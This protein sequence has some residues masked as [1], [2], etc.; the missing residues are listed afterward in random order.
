MPSALLDQAIIIGRQY[1]QAGRFADAE[2]A[3]QQV[4]AERPD[5]PIAL[6]S[7]A[8]LAHRAGKRD[9]ALQMLRRLIAVNPNSPALHNN[10]AMLLHE[11]GRYEEAI[12]EGRAAIALA[13]NFA[14]A[15]FNLGNALRD[16][17]RPLEARD[18]LAKA[19]ELDPRCMPAFSNL[20]NVLMS[21]G[22]NDEAIAAHSAAVRLAPGDAIAQCNFAAALHGRLRLDEAV[23]AYQAALRLN[24]AFA[25]GHRRLGLALCELGRLHEALASFESAMLLEPQN[26]MSL[27]HRLFTL[28]LLPGIDARTLRAEHAQW[29]QRYG[30]PR[31]ERMT[32][33]VDSDSAGHRR[34][35]V[36][37]VSADF[38]DHVVGR[39]I[40][41]LLREHDREAFDVFCYYTDRRSDFL[42]AKFR[43]HVT[44]WRDI[45]RMSDDAA[46][47]LIVD[48]RIDILVDFALHTAGNRLSLFA[49]KPA[50]IQ[51]AFAG[52]PGGTGLSAIDYRLTDP[53][54]DPPGEG[55]ET[56]AEQAL[57]L[58]D[59]FW[60]YDPEAMLLNIA[61][62]LQI[63][64]LPAKSNGRITFGCFSA[65]AKINGPALYLWARILH[66]TP[67][68]R[69]VL[70]AEEG[71]Q[72]KC[73]IEKLSQQ[74]ISSDRIG[75]LPRR[76]RDEYLAYYHAIDIALDTF[77]YNGHTTS[78]DAFW[79]GVPVVTLAGD[80]PVGRAGLS[81]L[82][83]LGLPDLV[84][85]SPEQYVQ[86]AIALANDVDRVSRL[87]S[88]LRPR[89]L[90]SPLTDAKRFAR[91]I[92][93]AYREIWRIKMNAEK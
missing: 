46:A 88:E 18:A 89:M 9:V 43:S 60:C 50:P 79:M 47:Q 24:P 62:D 1:A 30:N 19:T 78:L 20:G 38:R 53:Y 17:G 61:S 90:D 32:P 69:L 42:T 7:L 28:H 82:S 75:F 51:V 87:R 77:P 22:Q 74:G 34:L 4:L 16:C 27:S 81:Q 73:V 91:N 66:A 21:L 48:D 35:R 40:L 52:Y 76:P 80:L 25:E 49:R 72:R 39:N 10:C 15:Y 65:F 54:L 84:A 5:H 23:V 57:R 58:P 31:P 29:D 63:R 14:P 59:S 37:Y 93:S 86:T 64:P 26:P 85:F 70:I 12:A 92:E 41:P 83:N 11:L 8:E 68:S 13:P 67:G 71:G 44:E 45:A 2:R 33:H 56:G 36:G 6:H 3:Y 55:E